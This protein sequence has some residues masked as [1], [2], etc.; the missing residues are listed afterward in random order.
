MAEFRLQVI[1]REVCAAQRES[2]RASLPM[3][4]LL[5]CWPV[6]LSEEIRK[7]V[8]DTYP[9]MR[10]RF[11]PAGLTGGYQINDSYLHGPLK[12]NLRS[13]AEAWYAETTVELM[14][15]LDNKEITEKEFH[16]RQHAMFTL[17][18]LRDKSVGWVIESLRKLS[19]RDE[20]GMNVISKGWRDTFGKCFTKEF[21]DATFEKYRQKSAQEA[22]DG[23]VEQALGR[24]ALEEESLKLHPPRPKATSQ[25]TKET[26][27]ATSITTR[28]DSAHS[29]GEATT[30]LRHSG[31]DRKI[32]VC[33]NAGPRYK[34][35][36]T[37]GHLSP[38]CL[39]SNRCQR[40]V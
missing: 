24:V 32:Y 3:V 17:G 33:R 4:V 6:N 26:E 25:Q 18:L 40:E 11:I 35:C 1:E 22:L 23:Q 20:D 14:K 31:T 5:D 10:L 13:L 34:L 38:S 39:Y 19:E 37:Y 15:L 12:S 2:A 7:Y 28:C 16:D 36:N 30:R 21:Q 29:R 8:H 27:E 9:F